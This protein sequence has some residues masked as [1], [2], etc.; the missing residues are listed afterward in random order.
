MKSRTS[1]RTAVLL[2]MVVALAVPAIATNF[3]MRYNAPWYLRW[4]FGNTLTSSYWFTLDGKKFTDPEPVELPYGEWVNI[5]YPK[6][7]NDAHVSDGWLVDEENCDNV[8]RAEAAY[9][10]IGAVALIAGMEAGS[11]LTFGEAF[12]EDET[13]VAFPWFAVDVFDGTPPP[14]TPEDDLDGYLDRAIR[15]TQATT[16]CS[17]IWASR[18][19]WRQSWISRSA[20]RLRLLAASIWPRYVGGT[21]FAARSA[22]IPMR[23]LPRKRPLALQSLRA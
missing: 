14:G 16:T 18:I 15:L 2:L 21:G 5:P 22:G 4:L 11:P 1:F 17:S 10:G 20:L 3:Q 13:I 6:D 9:E 12:P 23:E 19:T 8:D 7:A